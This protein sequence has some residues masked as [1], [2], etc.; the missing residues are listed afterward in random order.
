MPQGEQKEESNPSQ[1]TESA[2]VETSVNNSTQ[3]IV[4][5]DQTGQGGEKVEREAPREHPERQQ[6]CQRCGS[7]GH[8]SNACPNPVVCSRCNKEGHVSRV[9]SA[10]MPG[11]LSHHF[12]GYEPMDKVSMLLKVQKLMREL[13][14]CR[15]LL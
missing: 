14:I 6:F 9:C 4:S 1:K 5:E 11:S 12:V 2:E 7:V 15:L 10:K 8:V 3:I 13:R